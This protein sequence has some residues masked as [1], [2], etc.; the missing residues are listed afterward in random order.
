MEPEGSL[1]FS[2]QPTTDP[3][4]EPEESSSHFPTRLPHD[5]F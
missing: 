1:L 2:Q 5:P 3:Y 4:P